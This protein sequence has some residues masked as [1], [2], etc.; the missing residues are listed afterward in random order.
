MSLESDIHAALNVA[1]VTALVGDRISPEE[2]PQHTA[3]PYVVYS[4][5]SATPVT[6]MAGTERKALWRV[7]IDSVAQTP[8]AA[9]E[10]DLAVCAAMLAAV[11]TLKNRWDD[12]RSLP[13]DIGTRR[14]ARSSDFMVWHT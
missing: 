5:V 14:H 10:L 9:A 2:A 7:Q 12:T 3:V 4:V 1:G 11:A 8:D 13:L 6:D